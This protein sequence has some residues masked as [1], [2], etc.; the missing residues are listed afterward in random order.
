[1]AIC[2]AFIF[3]CPRRTR[4]VGGDCAAT[5]GSEAVSSIAVVVAG[6]PLPLSDDTYYLIS[7]LAPRGRMP[8][9]YQTPSGVANGLQITRT[10]KVAGSWLRGLSLRRMR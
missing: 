2:V 5:S 9:R 1:M 8:E 7:P 6:P 10:T 3:S 4:D